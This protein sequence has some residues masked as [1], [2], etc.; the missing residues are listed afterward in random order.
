MSP[1]ARFKRALVT[2][3]LEL[4]RLYG[5][6]LSLHRDSQADVVKLGFSKVMLRAR[7]DKSGGSEAA[8]KRLNAARHVTFQS[9]HHDEYSS[10][11]FQE[12]FS[13]TLVR[14]W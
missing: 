6:T 14:C 1:S 4:A 10:S 5:L 9:P 2:L 13:N 12:G 11:D 3:L 8:T 7:P